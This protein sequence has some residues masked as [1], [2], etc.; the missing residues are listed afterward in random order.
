VIRSLGAGGPASNA[1]AAQNAGSE[2]LYAGMAGA[3]DGGGNFGGHLFSITTANTAN[4][5]TAWNDLSTSPVTNGQGTGFNAG[6]FDISSLAVDPHDSSGKTIYVTV[7]GFAGNGINAA[8]LYRS[9]DAGAHWTNISSN[10]PN[11]P[12]NSVVVDP[13][14][15]NT[16]YIAMDTGVYVTTQITTCPTANCWSVYGTSLPN[17]PV[18]ELAAASAMPTGDGRTGELRAA[19]Y[20]RGIWQVPLLTAS[21]AEQPAITMS[22]AAVTFGTQAVATASAAQTITVTNSGNA[23]L[24]LSKV[25]TAGDF[26]ETDNCAGTTLT[27]GLT[28]TIQVRFLPTATGSRSGLL[29]VYGNVAG[30]Q[31]TA[32]LSGT[33]SAAAPLFLIRY[34]SL[35]LLPRLVP[36]VRY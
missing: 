3:L 18:V 9:V 4:S 35:F 23:P 32:V 36:Q 14:D 1:A 30:G 16:V 15:L 13:N 34:L 21:T 24:I 12:A 20:G 11:A 27:V 25:A 6:G 33:A 31:A 22:P 7:M 26:D 19:T 28:C 29:T 5:T 10:L 17:A 8:H 2:V